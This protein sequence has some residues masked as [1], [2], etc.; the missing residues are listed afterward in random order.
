MSRRYGTHNVSDGENRGRVLCPIERRDKPVVA[1]FGMRRLRRVRYPGHGAGFAG[2]YESR[3]IDL[4][5][6][7]QVVGKHDAAELGLRLRYLQHHHKALVLFCLVRVER[8][9]AER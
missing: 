5:T 7:R 6:G 3:V 2:G 1:K 8:L 9:A 4:E